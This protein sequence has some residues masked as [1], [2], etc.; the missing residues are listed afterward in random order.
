[1][2]FI[3]KI[4]IFITTQKTTINHVNINRVC[5]YSYK[6]LKTKLFT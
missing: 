6:K 4:N 3:I 1:M 2:I 5:F